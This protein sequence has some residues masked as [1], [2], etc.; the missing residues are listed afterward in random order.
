MDLNISKKIAL[1]TGASKGIG[2]E[3]ARALSNEGATVV[4]NSRKLDDLIELTKTIPNCYPLC[5]DVT[6]ADDAKNLV[7]KV[8]ERFGRLDIL[9]CNVGSGA[10][11]K[12]GSESL[13]EWKRVFAI[14]MWSTTN[15]VESAR[16]ALTISHGSIVC[17]SS[18]CGNKPVLDA[19]LTY[20]SAKAALN[21]YVKGMAQSLGKVGVRINA[22]APGNIFFPGSVWAY[23]MEHDEVAINR[24]LERDVA[25]RRF[26]KAEEVADLVAYLAS[27]R[28]SFVTGAIWDIDGGQ[29]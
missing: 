4:V 5:G 16:E 17:I 26:G 20:S 29:V 8:I 1:V 18:I 6:L 28:S 24:M 3:I 19:P 15:V 14:N 11:V 25:L 27:P 22:V 23:K 21:S 2:L 9:V 7:L 13:D 10:S 12:P